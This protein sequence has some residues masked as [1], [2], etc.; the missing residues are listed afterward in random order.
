MLETETQ[1]WQAMAV[2]GFI[3]AKYVL[4]KANDIS[5]TGCY[6]SETLKSTIISLRDKDSTTTTKTNTHANEPNHK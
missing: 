6:E 3:E 5:A 2:H 4:S 1:H